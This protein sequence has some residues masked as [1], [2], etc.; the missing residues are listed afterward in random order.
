MIVKRH[1]HILY[2]YAAIMLALTSCGQD[3]NAFRIR[4]SFSDMQA[5]QLYIYNLSG[6]EAR[7]DTLTLQAGRFLY[8]GQASR[9][10]PCILVLPNGMEQVI[11][12]GPGEDLT[13]T[14]TA[15]DLKSYTVK[16][17]DENHLMNQFRQDTYD[18][19][20]TELTATA[21]SYI[22]E[23]PHTQ[24]AIYLLDQYF[25]QNENVS[26]TETTELLRVIK[27]K[28][29]HSHYLL[30]LESK[31]AIAEQGQPGKTLPNPLL[32]QK[33]KTS[34]PLW[35][36]TKEYNLIALWSTWQSGGYDVLWKLRSAS[37]K[38]KDTDSLRIVAISLDIQRYRWED[39]IRPDTVNGIEHYCDG[40]AFE[41]PAIRHLGIDAVPLYLLTD[42]NH[43]VLER[44]RDVQGIDKMLE[45][46]LGKES[47]TP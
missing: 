10:K 38:Y 30:D 4:G 1:L 26:A 18:Q 43:Q 42:K 39:A 29:P 6:D 35:H 2:I 27:Q 41:S 31:I 37:G 17:S 13:Y 7:I 5:G 32:V 45:K 28:Q 15:N 16:G 34:T 14:A 3:G 8:R 9:V 23:H 20:P 47:N 33:D 11:F 24:A 40:L 25:V 46:Y 44:S 21:R 36:Q 19:N 22:Q 12:V